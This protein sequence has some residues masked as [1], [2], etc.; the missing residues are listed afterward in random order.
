LKQEPKSKQQKASAVGFVRR[1]SV[2]RSD[3]GA[4]V[5]SVYRDSVSR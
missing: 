2:K 4:A 5:G 1:D 3:L